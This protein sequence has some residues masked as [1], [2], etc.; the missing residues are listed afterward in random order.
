MIDAVAERMRIQQIDAAQGQR[1][2]REDDAEPLGIEDDLFLKREIERVVEFNATC[3]HATL[4]RNSP[5]NFLRR[6]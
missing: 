6:P 1:G 4:P 2:A 5:G 3:Q